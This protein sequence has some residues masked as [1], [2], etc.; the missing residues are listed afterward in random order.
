M[1]DFLPGD[2][3]CQ[4][5]GIKRLAAHHRCERCKETE[6]A[7][8]KESSRDRAAKTKRAT[9]DRRHIYPSWMKDYLLAPIDEKGIFRLHVQRATDLLA[10]DKEL[11]R[12]WKSDPYCKVRVGGQ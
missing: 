7:P 9:T 5:L 10:T 2:A 3:T 8:K 6:A 4:C 11:M 1:T 12:S